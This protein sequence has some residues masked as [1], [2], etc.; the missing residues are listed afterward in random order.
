MSRTWP[1][2]E[3]TTEEIENWHKD[4]GVF[5]KD[6]I[7][8]AFDNWRRN[9]RKFPVYGDIIDLCIAYEPPTRPSSLCSIECRERHGK[10]YGENP[11]RGLHDMTRLNELVRRKIATEKRT[12]AKP[13]TDAEID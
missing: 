3:L 1:L 9:G 11:T 13:L 2:K 6:Q 4:L 12:L 5:Q 10:G 8:Q 7:E